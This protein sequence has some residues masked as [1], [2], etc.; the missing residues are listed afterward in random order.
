VAPCVPENG[1]TPA[2]SDRTGETDVCGLSRRPNLHGEWQMEREQYERLAWSVDAVAQATVVRK[3]LLRDERRLARLRLT[4][5]GPPWL[6]K[7]AE[8]G[9][10]LE[11]RASMPRGV[12]S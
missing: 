12:R 8:P 2:G 11:A 3:G 4:R 6:L 1:R 10:Y 7:H 5:L 9:R